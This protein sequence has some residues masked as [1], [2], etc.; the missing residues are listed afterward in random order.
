MSSGLSHEHQPRLEIERLVLEKRSSLFGPFLNYKV[1]S[2]NA[3]AAGQND[4]K[5]FFFF[6]IDKRQNKLECSSLASLCTLFQFL[7]E[8]AWKV[9]KCAPLWRTLPSNFRLGWKGLLGRNVLAIVV[10]LS[11][12]KEKDFKL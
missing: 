1:K 9:L 8:K 12:T 4:I 6:I 3:L 2:F 5:L 7:K 10:Y 11:V